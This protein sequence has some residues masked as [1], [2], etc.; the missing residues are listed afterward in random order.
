VKSRE[1]EEGVVVVYHNGHM[2]KVKSD[3]YVKVH[4]AKELLTSPRRFLEA[5][6]NETIDDAIATFLEDDKKKAIERL[7]EFYAQKSEMIDFMTRYYKFCRFLHPEKK[8]YAIVTKDI[9]DNLY[10][11]LVFKLWDGKAA[12]PEE[13]VDNWIASRVSSNERVQEVM[14]K[15]GLDWV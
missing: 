6:V 1:G 9:P 4:R 8:S 11:Q 15:L 2:L 14:E 13:V 5:I 10:R 7:K 3:W 12:T